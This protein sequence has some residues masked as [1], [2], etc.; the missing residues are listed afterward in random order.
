MLCPG[1]GAVVELTKHILVFDRLGRGAGGVESSPQIIPEGFNLGE[2]DPTTC[3]I[4]R[5]ARNKI[6]YT[7]GLR[8][9]LGVEP[10]HA[11]SLNELLTSQAALREEVLIAREHVVIHNVEDEIFLTQLESIERIDVLHHQVPQGQVGAQVGA[12]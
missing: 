10:I 4:D 11:Q 8:L 1:P 12:F 5:N 6:K 2:N 3:H 7:I 9:L